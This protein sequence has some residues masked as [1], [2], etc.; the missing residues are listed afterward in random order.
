MWRRCGGPHSRHRSQERSPMHGIMIGIGRHTQFTVSLSG[1]E[2]FIH[3]GFDR[4]VASEHAH[5][6]SI[7][8]Y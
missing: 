5:A 4:W 1:E 3:Y 8:P 2:S 7:I 6:E